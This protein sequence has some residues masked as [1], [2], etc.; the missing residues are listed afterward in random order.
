VDVNGAKYHLLYGRDDWGQCLVEQDGEFVPLS[1]LWQ[2]D[3]SHQSRAESPLEWNDGSAGLRLSRET[4]L[5]KLVGRAEQAAPLDLYARRGAGRDPYGNWYWIDPDESG[6][7]FLPVGAF[8]SVQYWTSA[9]LAA[10]CAPADAATF[11]EAKPAPPPKLSLCGLAVTT[12]HYLVVGDVTE[13][14][15]LLFDLH[16]GGTPTLLRWPDVPFEP[17]DIAPTPDGGV[18]V[19]DRINKTYWALDANFRLWADPEKDQA[20]LFQ[21]AD[22]DAP[23]NKVSLAVN[24]RG[25]RLE[26]GS[27]P[28]SISPIS[29]E[30]GPDGYVLI[31][32]TD[33]EGNPPRGYSIVYVYQG[34]TQ[35]AAHS[36]EKVVQVIDPEVGEGQPQDFPLVGHDLAYVPANPPEESQSQMRLCGCWGVEIVKPPSDQTNPSSGILYIAEHAGNQAMAFDMPDVLQLPEQRVD[37]L[38][39]RRWEGKG[40]VAAGQQVYYDFADRWIELQEFPECHYAGR[41]V[42][43]TPPTF[44]RPDETQSAPGGPLDSNQ[45]GCVWHRLLLDAHLPPGSQIKVRARAADSADLLTQSG[46]KDQPTPYL[47]SGGSEIP[48]YDPW[49]DVPPPLPEL[50]GTWELLFQDV[51]GRYLQLEL[52]LTG[53]GRSTLS[54]RSLRAWYPRFS[55]LEHYLPALYRE[56]PGSAFFLERWLANFEG[57]YTNLEDK[58]EHV[59]ELFDPLTAPPETLDWLGCWLGLA[60]DPLWPEDRRRFFIRNAH[61]LYRRRGTLPGLAI[62]LRLYLDEQVNDALFDFERSACSSGEPFGQVRIVERFKTRDVGGLVY[63]DPTRAKRG[64]PKRRPLT[65]QDVRDN[66]HRF[67]VLVPHTLTEDQQTMV[68]RIV[69]LEK[70]AHTE[71][72]VKQYWAMF[73]VGEA[74]V[75]IDT[76]LGDSSRFYPLLLSC[77]RL[78]ESYLQAPYP[79]DIPN[80]LVSDRDILGE[81]PAL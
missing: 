57:L 32:D 16:G 35:V 67:T 58:I 10:R 81:L 37:Y 43:V 11:A 1:K 7:R 59:A 30:A 51:G 73:R 39:M 21:P 6:L 34:E 63:G 27:P 76:K 8:E 15:L 49:A 53:T 77:A 5:F 13:H 66:A 60:L 28:E 64:A 46:W 17:W 78:N 40:L 74:R 23:P 48:F 26:T 79:F 2:A 25:Y 9:D 19:L 70:P 3:H 47:R 24:P 55:Y 20:A 33:V 80:R 61:R 14:G 38:P 50:T 75:G 52:T 36:L 71:C 31:L 42:L 65:R 41:A 22:P 4:P 72:E 68:E 12:Q 44:A 56:E 45:P 62:A 69:A 54:L 18:L 29:I